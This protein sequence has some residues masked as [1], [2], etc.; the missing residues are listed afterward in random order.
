MS[1]T[2]KKRILMVICPCIYYGSEFYSIDCCT[3]LHVKNGIYIPPIIQLNSTCLSNKNK[4]SKF[5]LIYRI[6]SQLYML[7]T[8]SWSIKYLLDTKDV[9]FFVEYIYFINILIL[10]YFISI[11]I[12]NIT[13]LKINKTINE[14]YQIPFIDLHYYKIKKCVIIHDILLSI[15]LPISIMNFIWIIII[16]ND[17][18]FTDLNHLNFNVIS[19]GLIL[20]NYILSLEN[21]KYKS[22]IYSV[23]FIGFYIGLS[24]FFCSYLGDCIYNSQINLDTNKWIEYS[25]LIIFCC[26]ATI[27]MLVFIKKTLLLKTWMETEY[28]VAGNNEQRSSQIGLKIGVNNSE[29]KSSQNIIKV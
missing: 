7:F 21:L 20:I 6:L 12:I 15:S 24:Y 10:F 4:L 13:S 27:F 18:Y 5:I 19:F 17:I 2:C 23:L 8:I 29:I 9:Y 26:I 16:N 25:L 1:L 28:T 22:F 3:V 14:L 11:V